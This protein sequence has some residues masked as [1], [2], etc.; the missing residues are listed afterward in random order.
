MIVKGSQLF[1]NQYIIIF[2]IVFIR[3]RHIPYTIKKH[4]AIG[5]FIY[6]KKS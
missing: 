3:Q 6:C 2:E 5:Y 1:I 4:K